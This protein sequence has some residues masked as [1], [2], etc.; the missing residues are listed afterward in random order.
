MVGSVSEGEL[1]KGDM[2]GNVTLTLTL[3]TEA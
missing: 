2:L 1:P 3:R